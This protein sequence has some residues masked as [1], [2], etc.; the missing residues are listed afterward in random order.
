MMITI[1]VTSS[2]TLTPICKRNSVKVRE[3]R[4]DN[5]HYVR[6]FFKKLIVLHDFR[7]QEN[8]YNTT[9]EF[10]VCVKIVFLLNKNN[11]FHVHYL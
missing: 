11:I 2:R 6:F 1:I 4:L 7:P 3:K 5:C 10:N 9:P 8:E